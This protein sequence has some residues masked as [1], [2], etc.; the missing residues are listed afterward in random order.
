MPQ[1]TVSESD[2]TDGRRIRAEL[3]MAIGG[4]GIGTGEFVIMG[5]LP[6]VA[7][8]THVPVTEAA[9]A[10]S[11]YALGVVVGAPVIAALAARC[12]RHVVLAALMA[13]FALGNLASA[14]APGLPWLVAARFLTGLPHGAYFG[15][16]SLVA[17][18][19]VPPNRR[20]QAVGRM[21]LGLTVATLAGVPLATWLGQS[22][23]WRAA[24][25]FVGLVGVVGCVS[26]RR[27]VPRSPADPS[28]SPLRELGALRRKQV[29]LTLG[30]GSVGL[31]G[32]FCVFSYI[33]PTMTQVAGLPER[34]MPA[35]LAVFG[36]GMISG[37]LIGAKLAD[38]A[39]KPT[40]AG[41]L[42]WNIIVMGFFTV[43]AH[44]AWLALLNLLLIAHGV[45][46]VPALQIRLMDVAEDAQ[47]LAASLNHS[48][49]NVANGLG[50]WLGGV[51]IDSGLGWTSTGW[52]G[53]LL[54]VAGLSIF[55]V[56]ATE[57]LPHT[58]RRRV[59][60]QLTLEGAEVPLIS[61]SRVLEAE[62]AS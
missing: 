32:L 7:E 8:H 18:S 4:F 33:T 30:V 48:A 60:P 20:A 11:A 41:A 40:I 36:V 2:L 51:A 26:I 43:T 12:R 1:D 46:L 3:A 25:V 28:A 42:I 23:G 14:M 17:A 16:A 13:C 55:L 6:E 29:L 9:H 38:R 21:M 57:S 59:A 22:F 44:N 31:G 45:A 61:P 49:F 5:L 35:V 19:L 10:I 37:N 15:V 39:L 58:R 56:S 24:F 47:T 50:A 27:F 62:P 53:A 52:V 54:A 34:L